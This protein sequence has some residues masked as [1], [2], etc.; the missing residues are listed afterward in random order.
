M[1]TFSSFVRVSPFRFFFFP[2][3]F[4]HF[5]LPS[6]ILCSLFSW[7]RISWIP[8]W[9]Q[10]HPIVNEDLKTSDL[11]DFTLSAGIPGTKPLTWL[12]GVRNRLLYDFWVFLKNTFHSLTI[13]NLIPRFPWHVTGLLW[14]RSQVILYTVRVIESLPD[15]FLSCSQSPPTPSYGL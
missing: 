11:P 3:P 10:T 5:F 13:T 8:G 7:E 12:T 2:L 15:G 6:F 14:T 1:L 9:S 4:P